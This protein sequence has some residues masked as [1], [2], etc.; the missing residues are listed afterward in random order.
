MKI[1]KVYLANS[2]RMSSGMSSNTIEC[3][4]LEIVCHFIFLDDSHSRTKM[5]LPSFQ[6]YLSLVNF[7]GSSYFNSRKMQMWMNVWINIFYGSNVFC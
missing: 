7:I 5:K 2:G 4:W 1:Y 6:V 3:S